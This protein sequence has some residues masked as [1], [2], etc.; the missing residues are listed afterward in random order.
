[1]T[2]KSWVYTNRQP[3]AS[4]SLIRSMVDGLLD[5]T[6]EQHANLESCRSKLHVPDDYSVDRS[7]GS[8]HSWLYDPQRHN[9][10]DRSNR[11]RA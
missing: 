9:R 10:R 8:W 1:M 4:L 6:E 11:S 5:E 3:L 2:E 7:S